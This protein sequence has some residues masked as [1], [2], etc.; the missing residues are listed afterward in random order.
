MFIKY[1]KLNNN[2]SSHPIHCLEHCASAAR[3][4]KTK[5]ECFSEETIILDGDEKIKWSKLLTIKASSSFCGDDLK[6]SLDKF[7][8]WIVK[9]IP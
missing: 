3:D 8:I 6:P 9:E 5:D 2:N 1:W 7:L 4:G